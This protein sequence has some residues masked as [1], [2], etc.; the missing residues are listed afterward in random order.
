MAAMVLVV[1][2]GRWLAVP[3]AS[4]PSTHL[5]RN[6][7]NSIGRHTTSVGLV[8]EGDTI[9][10]T[11]ASLRTWL[12]GRTV[13]AV[14]SPLPNL[15]VGRLVGRTIGDVR[16]IG[17]NLLVSF[18]GKHSDDVLVLHTHMKMTGSW[19]VYP[20]G[21][22]WRKPARQARI[23]VEA[24]DRIAVCFNAPVVELAG[25][26]TTMRRP[27]LSGL[28]PDVLV[29][30]LDVDRLLERA[31]ATSASY[32]LG[33]LLLDQF[34]V[35]GIGNIYRCEALF[36]EGHH[37]WTARCA[38]TDEALVDLV[39]RAA[40]LMQANLRTA[41]S[42]TDSLG[43]EFG[44]GGSRTWVYRRAG[45]G[46]RVCGTAIAARG[47]GPLARRAYWCPACQLPTT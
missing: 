43:R 36:L 9:A 10:R 5:T 32:A 47:Q 28:G 35:C 37:P 7:P 23:V 1:P 41:T 3:P 40:Q 45:L 29:E 14:T 25:P 30:P 8:P 24:G 31:E 18:V 6:S 13:T 39:R 21:A 44:A 4:L 17:K 11:A 46:C 27:S 34:V 15:R 16:P 26:G 2:L 22:A 20:A 42:G 38:L 19:H 33:E 12:G